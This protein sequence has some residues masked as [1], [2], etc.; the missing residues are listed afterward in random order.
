MLST[1]QINSLTVQELKIAIL[2]RGGFLGVRANS[3]KYLK[4]YLWLL[5]EAEPN[6]VPIIKKR[7]R[8]S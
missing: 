8:S 4:Y 6:V 1:E 5:R 7:K 3:L 2:K